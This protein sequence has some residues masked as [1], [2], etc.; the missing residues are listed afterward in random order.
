MGLYDYTPTGYDNPNYNPDGTPK[1]TGYTLPEED[2]LRFTK[3][4]QQKLITFI[5]TYGRVPNESEYKS[6]GIDNPKL[7]DEQLAWANNFITLNQDALNTKWE[8]SGVTPPGGAPAGVKSPYYLDPKNIGQP[9]T[10]A[11]GIYDM[12]LQGQ[13]ELYKQGMEGSQQAEVGMQS[14][15][16]G[17]RQALLDQMRNDRRTK[18]KS[19]LSSAQIANEEIQSLLMGQST[20]QQVAGTY[21]DQRQGVQSA[22]AL[23]PQTAAEQAYAQY[24]QQNLSGSAFAASG[25]GDASYQAAYYASLSPEQKAAYDKVTN[26]N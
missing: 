22:Y 21:F 1:T 15:L 6:A 16:A 9:G 10:P 24:A 7:Y 20:A 11:G 18:L 14:E 12:Y 4:E 3:A 8:A 17:N 2:R 13:E 19:G 26:P 25:A 23:A 5:E